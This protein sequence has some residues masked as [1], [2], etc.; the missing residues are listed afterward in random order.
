MP[1]LA[2]YRLRAC[3]RL[4]VEPRFETVRT[5]DPWGLVLSLNLHRRHLTSAQRAF[6]ALEVR[7]HFEV[8]MGRLVQW[9]KTSRTLPGVTHIRLPGEQGMANLRQAEKLG[10]PVDED[11][12]LELNEL[13]KQ[14]LV[15]GLVV[16]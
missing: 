3:R 6:L 2:L 5:E 12:F 1:S 9:L 13:A 10:V 15:P 7:K 8:E 11:M 16:A 4:G 14:Y